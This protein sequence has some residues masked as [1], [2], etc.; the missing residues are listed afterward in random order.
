MNLRNNFL[1]SN[2]KKATLTISKTNITKR[3]RKQNKILSIHIEKTPKIT[4]TFQGY[5]NKLE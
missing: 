3:K 2:V 4:N 5:K 1:S